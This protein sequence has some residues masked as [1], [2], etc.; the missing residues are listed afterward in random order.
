M[1]PNADQRH[2]RQRFPDK[3]LDDT[4]IRSDISIQDRVDSI[5]NLK[6]TEVAID[7]IIYDLKGF[8]HPGGDSFRIFGGNDVTA[9][10]HMI[11]PLHTPSHL[12][13]LK[14]VGRVLDWKQEYVASASFFLYLNPPLDRTPTIYSILSTVFI[15]VI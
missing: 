14:K 7:G 2:L 1:P 15:H 5:Q 6:D 13:K 9:M 3:A 8:N 12:K 10:Y 4:P 11:H